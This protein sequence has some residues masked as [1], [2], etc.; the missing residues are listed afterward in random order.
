MVVAFY[1]PLHYG[2]MGMP[3]PHF[4]AWRIFR[5]ISEFVDG[6]ESMTHIGPSVS[7]FGSARMTADN[8]YYQLGVDVA[9]KIA[10]Q[11]FAVITGGGGGIM[12][13]A[14]KGAQ[15]GGGRSCGVCIDLPFE[16]EPNKYIDPKWRFNFRY[17]FVR[18]VMFVRYAQAFVFLPGGVGTCD[19][20]FE[21]MTLIQTKKIRMFPIFLVGTKFWGGLLDWIKETMLEGG[22]ISAGDLDLITVTDDPSLVASKIKQHFDEVGKEP[23]FDLGYTSSD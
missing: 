20:L 9:E 8:P 6:F 17:F 13:A 23:T 4:D 7:I 15:K 1:E 16:A 22:Y 19:E 3:K 5:I 18:K 11:G 12:E 14:N 21:A 10:E 2:S